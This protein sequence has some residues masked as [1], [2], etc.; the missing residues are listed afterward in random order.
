M[1]K[2][3]FFTFLSIVLWGV[4]GVIPK[5]AG[6]EDVDPRLL[7]II[8]TIGVVPTSLL[9]VASPGF[10][11]NRNVSKGCAYAFATGVCASVGN[12]AFFLSQARGGEASVVAPLTGMFAI[13]TVVLAV[14][15]LGERLNGIQAGGIIVSLFAAY[16]L[17]LPDT[18]GI[19]A[20]LSSLRQHL[21]AAWMVYALAALG[22]WGVAAVLQKLATNNISSEL[23]T[24]CFA[25][26]FVPV[27]IFLLASQSFNWHISKMGWTFSI[28]L[29]GIIGIGGLTLF[30]A[31]RDGKASIVTALYALY[32]AL[33]VALA[34]PLFHEPMHLRKAIAIALA[35][36]AAIALSYETPPHPAPAP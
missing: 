10:R 9:L 28:L 8:S 2:W 33:T 5:L 30:A 23:S 34:I 16:L 29:G 15:L 24:V 25:L 18:A 7:Q 21:T 1:P 12:L 26:G 27:A 32:P 20:S 17:S 3:L 11:R 31:Y 4:W 35:L 22:L 13:V 36:A 6:S 19:T 14:L